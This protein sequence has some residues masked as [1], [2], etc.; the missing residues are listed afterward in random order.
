MVHKA[1]KENGIQTESVSSTVPR[2]QRK[3]EAGL[4]CTENALFTFT[5]SSCRALKNSYKVVY[6]SI[7]EA[8]NRM[9]ELYRNI[10]LNLTLRKSRVLKRDK[11]IHERK[12]YFTLM[13]VPNSSNKVKTI[14][15]SRFFAGLAAI[16]IL[17]AM[18][19]SIYLF[20]YISAVIT[21]NNTLRS[22]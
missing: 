20:S 21:E 13:V 1:V 14:R 6:N 18:V 16:F 8:K 10:K 19:F 7:K 5:K 4:P 3:Q 17:C 9:I 22:G 2:I 15:I 12:K 11:N